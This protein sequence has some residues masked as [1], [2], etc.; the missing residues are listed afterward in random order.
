M[1]QQIQ[2]ESSKSRLDDVTQDSSYVYRDTTKQETEKE[3]LLIQGLLV[4]FN[5]TKAAGK[6]PTTPNVSIP[7]QPTMPLQPTTVTTVPKC[8]KYIQTRPY[9]VWNCNKIIFDPNVSWIKVV[10]TYKLFTGDMM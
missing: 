4:K 8:L 6:S 10:C 2:S 7:L 1:Q 5:L 3:L 9:Q